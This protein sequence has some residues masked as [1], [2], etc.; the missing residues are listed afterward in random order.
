MKA[1]S[2]IT[3]SAIK[4]I[5]ENL[6]ASLSVNDVS[7]RIFVSR[8][9]LQKIF[10][11]DTGISAGK[12][13]EL[14]IMEIAKKHLDN[15]DMPISEISKLLGFCDRYYFSRRFSAV[16]GVSPH[17]YRCGKSNGA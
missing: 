16:Y 6:S 10:K 15:D 4:F 13:I 1:Y 8:S 7:S 11:E 3:N 12:Y 14:K 9:Y 5:N 2:E 17:K